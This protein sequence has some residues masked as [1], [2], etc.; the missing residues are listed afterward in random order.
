MK[1]TLLITLASV[2]ALAGTANAQ[3]TF[4]VDPL[5]FADA[6]PTSI[7]NYQGS[8]ITVSVASFGDLLVA[9]GISPNGISAEGVYYWHNQLEGTGK[10][11]DDASNSFVF[12]FSDPNGNTLQSV[13]IF[14]PD[15]LT[16]TANREEILTATLQ[17]DISSWGSYDQS[18]GNSP[19]ISGSSISWDSVGLSSG[20]YTDDFSAE[21]S[22]GLYSSASLEVSFESATGLDAGMNPFSVYFTVVPEPS[23]VLLLSLG[24]LGLLAR[25]KRS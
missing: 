20:S 5:D 8:G 6:F 3:T 15:I 13:S 18:Q 24:S 4:R 21:S 23:S 11:I 22:I 12:I 2:A 25:R 9:N 10:Y 17:G 1:K 14:S 19:T 16:Y 7:S